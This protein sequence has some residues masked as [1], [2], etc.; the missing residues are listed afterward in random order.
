MGGWQNCKRCGTPT[1][2]PSGYCPTC[3]AL[4]TRTCPSCGGTGKKYATDIKCP[5]CGGSGKVTR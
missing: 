4:Y 3:E 5:T 1:G 2:N